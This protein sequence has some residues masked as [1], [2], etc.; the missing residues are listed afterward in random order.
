MKG[1][2]VNLGWPSLKRLPESRLFF[3]TRLPNVSRRN[4]P[5]KM[6][7]SENDFRVLFAEIIFGDPFSRSVKMNNIKIDQVAEAQAGDF[8]IGEQLRIVKAL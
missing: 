5:Q 1:P 6:G 4:A 8:E 3:E 7:G 2:A